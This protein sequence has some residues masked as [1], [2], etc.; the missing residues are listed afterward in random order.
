[1]NFKMTWVGQTT[2]NG[3]TSNNSQQQN[4]VTTPLAGGKWGAW[5]Q[6]YFINI[7]TKIIKFNCRHHIKRRILK[8]KK[9]SIVIVKY[10][11]NVKWVMFEN[12]IYQ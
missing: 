1:M 8:V 11:E 3:D 10:L 5:V 7:V 6:H 12:T 2:E 9:M 4:V